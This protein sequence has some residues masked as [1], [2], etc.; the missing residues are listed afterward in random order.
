MKKVIVPL[1]S[2][3]RSDVLKKGQ[4][5]YIQRIADDGAYGVEIRRELFRDEE[6]PLAALKQIIEQ[7]QLFAVY[8]APVELW[9][10]DGSLND[11]DLEKVFREAERI[12]ARWVKV[13]LG[14]YQK[15]GSRFSE[16][17]EFLNK[18][19]SPGT[20]DIHLLVENDQTP[21]GGR[22]KGLRSF[23]DKVLGEGVPIRMTFDIGN[24]RYAGEN[25]QEAIDSLSQFVDYLHL[26]HVEEKDGG[27]VTLPLPESREADWRKQSA[28]FPG[29]IVKALEF[30]FESVYKIKDYIQL[31]SL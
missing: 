28:F 1:N 10:K 23:F 6:P 5:A 24:W 25:V 15:D 18:N 21:H 30:P 31:V 13:S 14:H 20:E 27:L 26:K 8:S 16:L 7:N 22:I 2:F 9:K 4:E 12:G 3:P 11:G 17:K 29:H 19:T